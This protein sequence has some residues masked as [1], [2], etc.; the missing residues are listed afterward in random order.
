MD[1][2]DDHTGSDEHPRSPAGSMRS[3]KIILGAGLVFSA[4]AIGITLS[5]AP[6]TVARVNTVKTRSLGKVHRRTDIC[7]PNETLPR[8][9][10][11]IRLRVFAYT[12]PRVTVAV[13]ARERLIARGERESGW[14]SGVVTIPVK[15]L[16]TARS[17]VKLCFTLFLNG[18]EGASFVGERTKR[19]PATRDRT[20]TL[21]GRIRVEYLRPGRASWWS[22]AL[23][24]ARRMGLG[25][26]GSG[27]WSVLLVIVLMVSV[28]LL[29]SRLILREL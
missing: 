29:C 26:A 12:G 5:Q 24:V 20:T 11:A 4:A 1:G 22:Q 28:V 21:P 19:A 23:S 14:T 2:E 9:T 17:G 15:P 3:I 25:H 7:Q 6:I 8:E 16:A 10:S 18:D 27:T 13:L